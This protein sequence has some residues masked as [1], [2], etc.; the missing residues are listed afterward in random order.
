MSDE[1]YSDHI[2]RES[3][4]RTAMDNE[5]DLYLQAQAVIVKA[6][7]QLQSY[8][9]KPGVIAVVLGIGVAGENPTGEAG[10]FVDGMS[11][12]MQGAVDDVITSMYK[13]RPSTH[14]PRDAV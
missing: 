11:Q 9:G 8:I 13:H 14:G 1:G 7:E 12:G 2:L 5:A 10:M 6:I 3:H 4:R